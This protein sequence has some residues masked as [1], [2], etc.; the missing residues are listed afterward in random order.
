[1]FIFIFAKY[2]Y[3]IDKIFN[4]AFTSCYNFSR[5]SLFDIFS[6]LVL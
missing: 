4:V 6:V 3:Q 1:M 2:E 5:N